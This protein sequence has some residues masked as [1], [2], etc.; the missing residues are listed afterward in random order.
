MCAVVSSLRLLPSGLFFYRDMSVGVWRD[1]QKRESRM[2]DDQTLPQLLHRG[3]Q[4]SLDAARA[5]L[6]GLSLPA[7]VDEITGTLLVWTNLKP[8]PVGGTLLS[9]VAPP[10][11]SARALQ[12]VASARRERCELVP[13]AAIMHGS[14]LLSHIPMIARMIVPLLGDQDGLVGEELLRMIGNLARYVLAVHSSGVESQTDMVMSL[15]APFIGAAVGERGRDASYRH[16]HRSW[17]SIACCSS[18]R[19][20]C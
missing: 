8:P 1:E 9:I 18:C 17:R 10:V 13:C 2:A 16:V 7:I 19:Q 20:N 14:L 3:D 12:R 5:H 4:S 6:D 11:S 15:A